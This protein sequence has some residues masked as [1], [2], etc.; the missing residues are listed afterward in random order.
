MSL[1]TVDQVADKLGC[2]KNTVWNMREKGLLPPVH[3]PTPGKIRWK[4]EDIDRLVALG[5]DIERFNAES[6]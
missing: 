6:N 1:L 4:S 3:K 5:G 2:C